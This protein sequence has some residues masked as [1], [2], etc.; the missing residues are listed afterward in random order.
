MTKKKP[1][2]NIDW[3]KTTWKGSRLQ[4]HRKFHALPFARKLEI[5]EKL[6]DAAA[7]LAPLTPKPAKN[8]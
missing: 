8:K 5:I 4:Q 1:E 3:S 6:A 2:P 7:S